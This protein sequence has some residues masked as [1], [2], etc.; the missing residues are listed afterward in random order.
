M[1]QSTMISQ[2]KTSFL[3]LFQT[4]LIH[5][6]LTSNVFISATII[7]PST[8]GNAIHTKHERYESEPALFGK[9]FENGLHYSAHLQVVSNSDEYLCGGVYDATDDN[10]IVDMNQHQESQSQNKKRS[11]NA[12]IVEEEDDM[13]DDKLPREDDA[14]DDD[15]PDLF[16]KLVELQEEQLKKSRRNDNNYD[17]VVPK[18]GLPVVLLV[19]RGQ[20]RFE[21]KA[22]AAM[23]LHAPPNVIQ[24]LIVYDNK[25][26]SP[27]V[28]MSADVSRGINLGLLFT[29]SSAGMALMHHISTHHFISDADNENTLP[30]VV[31]EETG[32]PNI[33]MEEKSHQDIHL[34]PYSTDGLKDP[35]IAGGPIIILD[36]E[37]P[38]IPSMYQ[39]TQEWIVAVLAGF[40]MF[41]SCVSCV[42]FCIH[43]GYIQIQD[44]VIIVGSRGP[45]PEGWNNGLAGN[46]TAVT[47]RLLTREEVQR[48]PEITFQEDSKESNNGTTSSSDT[49]PILQQQEETDKEDNDN[50]SDNPRNTNQQYDTPS[51][52][53]TKQSKQNP[54][55]TFT[56]NHLFEC[57]SC[58]VCLDEYVSGDILQVLPCKHSFHKH[59]I[60]PWLT[61]RQSTCP[62]CK[63]DVFVSS[64]ETDSDSDALLQVQGPIS[65]STPSTPLSSS[66]GT[67]SSLS[68]SLTPASSMSSSVVTEQDVEEQGVGRRE[69][70]SSENSNRS[71][72]GWLRRSDDT[73]SGHAVEGSD[74]VEQS[75]RRPLLHD[76]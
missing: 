55:C 68:S 7:V 76:Q 72:T 20:C 52:Q 75:L 51:I 35:D 47:Q 32:S 9:K 39:D 71:W 18:D 54:T 59:C 21:S 41:F 42:F 50:D 31:S 63:S 60:V 2:T 23:K 37:P 64:S 11:N 74:S 49:A 58:S 33:F 43:S 6:I 44:G 15:F 13:T 61:E 16:Q 22:R 12:R 10:N 67:S 57:N 24:Y 17:I 46:G 1:G 8:K 25:E 73:T 4:L 36:A 48:L 26:R 69:S 66:T 28:P 19:K 56:M 29:S 53:A 3:F 70:S 45:I 27:L 34:F 5:N 65:S 30:F 62:L 38:N 40:I 14:N